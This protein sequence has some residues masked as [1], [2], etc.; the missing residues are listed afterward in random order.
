MQEKGINWIT[1]LSLKDSPSLS[2]SLPLL[3]IRLLSLSFFNYP[4]SLWS[5][6]LF[7]STPS[8]QHCKSPSSSLC[9]QLKGVIL[10]VVVFFL[11]WHI[12]LPGLFEEPCSV[13]AWRLRNLQVLIQLSARSGALWWTRG[14]LRSNKD[15]TAQPA[16]Q[17]WPHRQRAT[18]KGGKRREAM[19]SGYLWYIWK[20]TTSFIPSF[21]H[22]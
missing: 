5:Y 14:R 9:I 2:A 1:P 20:R 11:S 15:I 10:L 12:Y 18:S 21:I 3:D 4:P 22:R 19:F 13:L 7:F 8:S 17:R 16:H 6:C